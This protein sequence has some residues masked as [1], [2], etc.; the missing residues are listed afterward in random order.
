MDEE[1]LPNYLND[2]SK[3]QLSVNFGKKIII[4]SKVN[5][6]HIPANVI[7]I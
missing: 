3:S 5:A 2:I 1:Y 4:S 7:V 6:K